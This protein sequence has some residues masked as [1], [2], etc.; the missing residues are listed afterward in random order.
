MIRTVES[1]P[2]CN[3]AIGI[4]DRTGDIVFNPDRADPAPCPHLTCFWIILA[5]EPEGDP[6]E[7]RATDWFW[8]Y[9]QGLRCGRGDEKRM[10]IEADELWDFL[11]SYPQPP[12]IPK[13]THIVVGGSAIEREEQRRG[14]GVLVID[15]GNGW[16]RGHLDD[17]VMFALHPS[18]VIEEV[19]HRMWDE[20]P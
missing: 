11:T 5:V 16:G 12:W 7:V 9:G 18:E 13:A 10:P 20:R 15:R 17:W 6:E 3:A 1:C 8:E 19:K 4:D 14:S 2:Y